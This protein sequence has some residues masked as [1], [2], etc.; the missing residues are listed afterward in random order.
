M[1][2]QATWVVVSVRGSQAR[3]NQL[4]ILAPTVDHATKL[5][6]ELGSGATGGGTDDAIDGKIVVLA[7]P[8]YGALDF[9]AKRGGDLTGRAAVVEITNP[10]DWAS[11]DRLVTPSD[12]SAA[13]E[14]AARLPDGVPV[15]KAFNTTFAGTLA[16]GE[17]AGQQLDVLVAADDQDAKDPT[18]DIGR[19]WAAR[20]G[21]PH[22]WIHISDAKLG[23]SQVIQPTPSRTR[24]TGESPAAAIDRLRDVTPQ[25]PPA[26]GSQ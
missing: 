8:Y 23:F 6:A 9:V 13:Q 18:R 10:V 21:R 20:S 24:R 15:V 7:T 26:S 14:I 5:A 25:E 11:F 17:V 22:S 3:K 19:P 1:S 4:Q 12:S 2:A 16:S